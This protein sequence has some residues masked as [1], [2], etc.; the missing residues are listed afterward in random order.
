MNFN[1]LSVI[2]IR[3]SFKFILKVD[4]EESIVN[5]TL[6]RLQTKNTPNAKSEVVFKQ[7]IRDL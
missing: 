6:V 2:N 1:Y 4:V 7:L 5:A 3:C